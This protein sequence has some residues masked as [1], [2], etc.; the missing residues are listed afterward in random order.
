MVFFQVRRHP[1]DPLLLRWQP[2][3]VA[4]DEAAT[5]FTVTHLN[6]EARRL[7]RSHCGLAA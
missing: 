5:W 3:R 4:G 7:R 2:N 6:R 1:G